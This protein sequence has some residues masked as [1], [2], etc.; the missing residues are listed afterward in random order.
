M[1][2][3]CPSCG[4]PLYLRRTRKL[5][6]LE[7]LARCRRCGWRGVLKILYCGVCKRYSYFLWEDGTWRCMTCGHTRWAGPP[8]LEAVE[9]IRAKA[10]G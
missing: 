6:T 9:Y 5:T 8:S 3:R 1:D 7:F 10:I 4:E 2:V